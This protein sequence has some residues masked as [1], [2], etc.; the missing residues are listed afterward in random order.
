MNVKVKEAYELAKKQYANYGVDVANVLNKLKDIPISIQ[1][2][3]GDDVG[4]FETKD[5]ALSDAGIIS[6]GSYAGKARNILELRSDIKRVFS[7]IPGKKKLSL[8]AIYGDFNGKVVNRNEIS[9]EHFP[10]WID[11][12]KKAGYRFRL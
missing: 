3:Q 10:S 7:L 6:T 11:W 9:L 1:C 5:N 8:H 4:G 2:W 12:A